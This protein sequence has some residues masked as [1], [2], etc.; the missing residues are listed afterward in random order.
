MNMA[1]G[2]VF[3]FLALQ[4]LPSP[5]A[6]GNESPSARERLYAAFGSPPSRIRETKPTT[7]LFEIE[8]CSDLCDS[9]VLPARRSG[10]ELWDAVLIFELYLSDDDAPQYEE[11][12][13]INEEYGRRILDRHSAVLG[14]DDAASVQSRAS[15]VLD[16]IATKLVFVSLRKDVPELISLNLSCEPVQ[17]CYHRARAI[18][19]DQEVEPEGTNVVAPRLMTL[20]RFSLPAIHCS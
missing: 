4:D 6:S 13:Q 20:P 18:A 15:C 7:S 19:Q 17:L 5:L 8:I 2:L 14:C 11:F 16:R 10:R 1:R 12:R 3:L 9:F